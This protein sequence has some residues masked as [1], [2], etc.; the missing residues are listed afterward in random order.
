MQ[1]TCENSIIFEDM[2]IPPAQARHTPRAMVSIVIPA[3]NEEQVLERLL[4]QLVP[5]TVACDLDIIVVANGCTDNTAKVAQSFEPAVR[6]LSIP[7]ASKREALG[8]GNRA[9]R[10]FP[11][12]Y[13]DADVELR[14]EDAR[15]LTEALNCPGTLA[16]A[17]ASIRPMT[18]RTRLVRWYYDI[19]S[20]LPEVQRGL[21]GRGV[22]G[23]SAEG[24]L[25]IA[26]LPALLADD[27]AASLMFS[28][29]ERAV[30]TDARVIVHPPRTLA[31]LLHARTR[32]VMGATQIEQTEGAPT[33][34]ARTRLTDLL[35]I[36]CRNPLL[37]PR[38]ALFLAV[39]M[40]ARRRARQVTT[41]S[42]YS[43]WLRDESSRG[44]PAN[45]SYPMGTHASRR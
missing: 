14:A 2:P 44:A 39:A 3:H 41:K 23:V 16:A 36:A 1:L 33:S 32:A 11:R 25:R 17:P 10:G 9:A 6:V 22:V 19:W 13:V 8:A 4:G 30:V 26:G 34:T 35:W 42:G 45:T 20:R 12:L 43:A 15:I 28:P 27:L 31:D 21:F 29:A 18:G 38:V 40:L 24:Y 37:A 5:S 7:V